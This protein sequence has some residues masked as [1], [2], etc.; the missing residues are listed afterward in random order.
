M[1]NAGDKAPSF[2]LLSDSGEKISLKDLLDKTLVLYFYPRAD[3]PGCTS[4]ANQFRD[5]R[6]ELQKA[7][8]SVAGVSGDSVEDLQKF[9]DKYSLNFPLLSDPGHGALEAY[10]V[11]QEKNMYGRK[12][13][14]IVR[15][16]FIIGPDGKVKKV[17]PRVKVDGHIHEVLA[18][19]NE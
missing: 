18:A 12:S 9:R 10:G 7:G 3:T 15:T 16:T 13:M 6:K 8:A 1:L 14:G 2:T 19:L 5:A 4:E 11:W 17:F